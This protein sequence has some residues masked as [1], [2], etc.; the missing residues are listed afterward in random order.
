M[1]R[2]FEFDS[3]KALT[4]TAYLAAETGE[5]M[6]P[7]LK[8]LYLVDRLHLE[9]YGRPVTGDRYVAMK[10]GPAPSAIYDCMKFLRG[11]R[12]FSS[13]PNA[14]EFLEVNRD[15]HVVSVRKMP[16]MD[17]FSSTDIECLEAIVEM[18]RR[19]GARSVVNESHDEAWKATSR[20]KFMNIMTIAATLKDGPVLTQHL[21]E[22]F[23]DKT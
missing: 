4:A 15:T 16:S 2:Q 1:P 3:E 9:R 7:I 18:F 20:N 5:T 21:A 19:K 23:P 6:Y 14:E 13:C 17:V 10:E 8:M 12:Q 11:D 22:R